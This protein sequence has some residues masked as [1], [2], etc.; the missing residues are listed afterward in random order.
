MHRGRR[1]A[2]ALHSRIIPSGPDRRAS[3]KRH[4]RAVTSLEIRVTVPEKESAMLNR[5]LLLWRRVCAWMM[6]R[7]AV[8][9]HD[10]SYPEP[11]QPSNLHASQR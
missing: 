3:L 10:E 2:P 8:P 7:P 11:Y 9:K 4:Y 1:R 5:L 6:P